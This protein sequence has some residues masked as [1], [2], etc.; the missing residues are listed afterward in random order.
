MGDDGSPTHRVRS[1]A[2]GAEPLAQNSIPVDSTH[3][4]VTTMKL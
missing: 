3:L 4:I 2:R 1:E